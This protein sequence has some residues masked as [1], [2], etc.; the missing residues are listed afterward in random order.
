MTSFEKI[1]KEDLINI[2]NLIDE[3]DKAIQL[4]SCL[5]NDKCIVKEIELTKNGGGSAS[6]EFFKSLLKTVK[7]DIEHLCTGLRH[8]LRED[9]IEQLNYLKSRQEGFKNRK[10]T[11]LND[12]DLYSLYHFSILLEDDEIVTNSWINFAKHY[13]YS[14]EEIEAF[15][16]EKA[17]PNQYSPGE[18]IVE[19]IKGYGQ[20]DAN[21]LANACYQIGLNYIYQE[22]KGSIDK[23]VQ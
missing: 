7:L 9:C 21:V 15:K 4:A 12:F 8:F 6:Y 20:N 1:K 3:S 13:Q 10:I 5:F 23:V 14:Q 22:I 18:V 2:I 16:E 19:K 17:L 11:Y